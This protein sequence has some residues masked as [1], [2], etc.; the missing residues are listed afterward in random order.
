MKHPIASL[1]LII[2]SAFI[3]CRP[4]AGQPDVETPL[5]PEGIPDNPI[6]YAEETVHTE[7]AGEGSMCDRY[8]VFSQVSDPAYELILP[9]AGNAN[10]VG[11]V[12]CPGGGLP[13]TML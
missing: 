9:E 13:G 11:L 7:K 10:G 6:S 2:L 8:R 3:S 5:W 4:S 1:T 12:I